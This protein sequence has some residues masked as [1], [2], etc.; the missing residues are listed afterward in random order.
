[1]ILF[2]EIFIF[3]SLIP[4]LIG[5]FISAPR[6]K[7]PVSDH[8]N[9]KTFSNPGN[10]KA[11]GFRDVLPWLF[12]RKRGPWPAEKGFTI[13]E[14]P[15]NRVDNG[16]RATFVNHSTFLLQFDGL[17]FLTDPVWSKRTS[18]VEWAGPKRKRPPGIRFEDLPKIDVVLISH[19]H[20][21]HLDIATLKKINE[22]HHPKFV[23]SLG[24][25]E[26]L[27]KHGIIS[28]DDLDWWDEMDITTGMKIQ[29]VPAQHFSGRGMFD[30]DGTLWVGY[31]IKRSGGNIY[32]AGDS[33]YNAKTFKEIGMKCSPISIAI[34]PIG[35]Y[36]PRWF[37]SP[38]HCSPQEAVAIHTEIKATVS[39]AAHFGTFQLADDGK[40][41]PTQELAQALNEQGVNPESFIVLKEGI[42][43]T[44]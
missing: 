7:G 8:F 19:N 41:E 29:A 17:N 11:K 15:L 43:R 38:I 36:Q 30:R 16:V 10:A 5:Y 28:M 33:G 21:D 6:Y 14:K 3:F 18:P 26:Y 27:S 22:T 32:F 35:A 40:Y 13:G 4:A 24:V 31:V 12:T 1:M 39:I 20:W 25:G 42:A 2:F 44:I 34:I 37:M 23:T 9:G